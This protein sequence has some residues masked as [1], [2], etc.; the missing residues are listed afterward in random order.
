MNENVLVWMLRKTENNNEWLN[1]IDWLKRVC[2][3]GCVFIMSSPIKTGLTVVKREL[4]SKVHRHNVHTVSQVFG[5]FGVL[6]HPQYSISLHYCSTTGVTLFS[7]TSK[8]RRRKLFFVL[9]FLWGGRVLVGYALLGGIEDS[10]FCSS[11]GWV[12]GVA[13]FVLCLK[14]WVA[15]REHVDSGAR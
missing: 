9:F 10:F 7:R 2:Q 14:M 3:D 11:L 5:L 12:S 13:V 6:Y 15:F 8:V 1:T 4:T